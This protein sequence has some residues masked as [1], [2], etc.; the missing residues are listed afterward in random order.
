ME[1]PE[2]YGLTPHACVLGDLERANAIVFHHQ[3][4]HQGSSA[5]IFNQGGWRLFRRLQDA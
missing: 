1:A 2:G 4:S 3:G 5:D